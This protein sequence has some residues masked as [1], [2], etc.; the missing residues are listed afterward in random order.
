MIKKIIWNF[1]SKAR[2]RFKYD[3]KVT[4]KGVAFLGKECSFEGMNVISNETSVETTKVGYASYIGARCEI[5]NTIIGRYTCIGADVK[6][7]VGQH[8]TRDY[9]SIHPAFF[10]VAKQAGFT[11]SD[12]Q[13]YNEVRYA[14]SEGH[15]VC[16][17]NDV[18]IGTDVKLC[19]GVT[20][21]DGAI[22]AAG[23]VVTKDVPEDCLVAGVPARVVKVIQ[24]EEGLFQNEDMEKEYG[25]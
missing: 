6:L 18:W 12:R 20:I 17:G 13:T 21:G 8:P 1:I 3:G 16:I 22:V 5:R 7:I 24:Q 11:Y 4:L 19:G 25:L 9:V 15:Y 10:S 14:D 2:A 23:A